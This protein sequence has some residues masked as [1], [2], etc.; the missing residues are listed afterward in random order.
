MQEAILRIRLQRE[1][2]PTLKND[3]ASPTPAKQLQ[4]SAERRAQNEEGGI[5]CALGVSADGPNEDD[6]WIELLACPQLRSP[7]DGSAY[8][9]ESFGEHITK[10]HD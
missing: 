8:P 1:D 9:F 7:V 6:V 2:K 10:K 5:V 3:P 4:R